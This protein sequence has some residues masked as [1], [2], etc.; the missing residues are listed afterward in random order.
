MKKLKELYV[1]YKEIIL[2]LFF[3]VVTTVVSLAACFVTL[4]VGVM[5]EALRDEAGEP[6]ELLD[7]LGSTV[8]WVS[9][10]LVAFFTNKK[11]VFTDAEKG[12]RA[13]VKQFFTFCGSR[14]G[15]YFVEVVI[16]LG[17]IALFEALNYRAPTLNLIIFSIVLSARLWAKVVSSVVVVISNYFI[18]KLLVFKKK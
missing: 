18:S 16:N 12:K 13:G 1:K 7:V 10:V 17:V 14:V 8:Q 3:G 2:Y 11:W 9:G 4:K 6:T 5:F 15:T